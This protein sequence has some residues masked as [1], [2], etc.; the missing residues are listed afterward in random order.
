MW[1]SLWK[2]IEM[3][4]SWASVVTCVLQLQLSIGAALYKQFGRGGTASIF[5]LLIA[6]KATAMWQRRCRRY[7]FFE[8][9]PCG[10]YFTTTPQG[11]CLESKGEPSMSMAALL[12]P[13]A[14]EVVGGGAGTPFLPTHLL[15]R[16][17]TPSTHIL[18]N[19]VEVHT[20]IL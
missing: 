15:W 9:Q 2:T 7:Y 16:G 8:Q 5:P 10:F 1:F 4:M 20:R 14:R 19:S 18:N 11:T 3:H 12:L 17:H 6:S 13:G